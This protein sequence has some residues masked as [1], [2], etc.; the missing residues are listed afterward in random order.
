MEF[1]IKVHEYVEYIDFKEPWFDLIDN[2]FIRDKIKAF[3]GSKLLLNIK[4]AQIFKEYE[5]VYEDV[6]N[7]YHGIID[8]MLVYSSHIDIIDYK[9]SNVEDEAYI[10][11]LNGY[12][13]YIE[14]I[15]GKKV[16][17]YL[18]SILDGVVKEIGGEKIA[19]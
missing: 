2:N 7:V 4:D 18:Y 8:C 15:T 9:L 5:F 6:D 17:T 1:V 16:R 10:N 19:V 14:K 13:D 12:K 11:Q 3:L